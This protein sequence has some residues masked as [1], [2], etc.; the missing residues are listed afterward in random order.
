MTKEEEIKM[1]KEKARKTKDMYE[2]LEYYR[3]AAA[4]GDQEAID[5]ELE[6]IRIHEL[7]I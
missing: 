5:E 7:M 3:K 1:W 2:S 6:I 4:L